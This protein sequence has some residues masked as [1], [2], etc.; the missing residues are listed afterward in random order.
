MGSFLLFFETGSMAPL[1]DPAFAGPESEHFALSSWKI[2]NSNDRIVRIRPILCM[3]CT[4]SEAH[5][6]CSDHAFNYITPVSRK[7]EFMINLTLGILAHV[8]AGKTTLSEALLYTCGALKKIGR[9]DHRDAFLDTDSMERSRGITIYSKQAVFRN[10][11]QQITLLDTPGHADF[12][13]ETERV[14]RVL[15][16]AIL[17]ISGSDGVQSHTRTLWNLLDRYDVPVFIFVNKMDQPGND[18][19]RVMEDLR[20]EFGP[21]CVDFTAAAGAEH[22]LP[23]GDTGLRAPAGAAGPDP[24]VGPAATGQAAFEEWLENVAVCED[25]MLQTLLETGSLPEEMI[26]RAIRGRSVVPCCFGSALKLQGIRELASMLET[27]ADPL[28]GPREFGARV[29]K[30]SHD[31]KG[32]RLVHMKVTGGAL[33][34]RDTLTGTDGEGGSW[35]EKVSRIR[36]YNG[37]RFEEVTEAPA[38]TVCAVTGLAAAR[39]SDGFGFEGPAEEPLLRPVLAYRLVLPAGADP[40]L[41]YHQL[42]ELEEEEPELHLAWNEKKQEIT[43]EVMGEVQTEILTSSIRQRFGLDVT[44]ADGTVMYRETIADTVEG[45][46][47]FEPLRHYAEVHLLMEPGAPGSGITITSSVSEDDLAKNWQ[48]LILTHLAE[49]KHV[50]VLTGSPLTDVRIT[51]AAGRASNKHTQ[52]GDFRQATYRAVRQG[53]M[54]ADCVLLEPYYEYTL[55]LPSDYVGRA[56]TDLDNMGAAQGDLQQTETLSILRG[57]APVAAIRNYQ[58]EVSAYTRGDGHLSLAISGFEPC[59][60]AGEVIAAAGYDAE[61]D[62]RNPPHS[63]FCGNGSSFTVPWDEVSSYMHLPSIFSVRPENDGIGNSHVNV[64]DSANTD[65]NAPAADA[66][67]ISPEEVEAILNRTAYAN[68]REER[69][70]NF[71]KRVDRGRPSS[72]IAPV[73]IRREEKLDKYL[74][75]DGYNVIF[76][77]KELS[78]LAGTDINA[79]REKLMDILVNYRAMTDSDI[80]AV[81]DAYRVQNHPAETLEYG[82]VYVVYTKTAQTADAYIEKFVHDHRGRFDITVVTSDALEQI[83]IRGQGAKLLSSREFELTVREMNDHIRRLIEENNRRTPRSRLDLS[84]LRDALEEQNDG[85]E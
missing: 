16:Y 52:G 47:H 73:H 71:R 4:K 35:S 40:R 7:E 1:A 82:P 31:E 56:M 69:R 51:L 49:K 32:T 24:A 72:D 6:S 78:D 30:I 80:I 81:F 77:W 23:A 26:R 38:G 14:L 33:R 55:T 79:A 66:L 15:D 3:V 36:V 58:K 37:A 60:N 10:G 57:R 2:Y 45:I 85:A 27:W 5:R 19:A 13:A 34:V 46:G 48:R 64:D 75:V 9:V 74:L 18:P 42:Q 39:Q 63:V 59:H 11:H 84:A 67:W 28:P 21:R 61:A 68:K 70:T 44:F 65:D 8:D 50:G 76:A 54:Q 12:S 53:L 29:F 22:R 41:L 20:R 17:V 83:I 62:L 25:S 43:A